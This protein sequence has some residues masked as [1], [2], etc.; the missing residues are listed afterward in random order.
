MGPDLATL[1]KRAPK[2]FLNDKVYKEM[3][4][5]FSH[6]SGWHFSHWKSKDSQLPG[7]AT[8]N[9]GNT[10]L[11]GI[12][13]W[14]FRNFH[15]KV[16]VNVRFYK[17][18]RTWFGTTKKS[19]FRNAFPSF[20]KTCV[21][22]SISPPFFLRKNK[23]L[24]FDGNTSLTSDK[25][26]AFSMI[27]DR[28]LRKWLNLLPNRLR[29]I[30]FLHARCECAN[31][32]FSIVKVAFGTIAKSHQ[33]SAIGVCPFCKFGSDTRHKVSKYNRF[34]KYNR[35]GAFRGREYM[36]YQGIV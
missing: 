29:F 27:L 36:F 31:V 7:N 25:P 12:K 20:L 5:A 15:Q 16:F 22:C 10:M 4:F 34:Y 11:F 33:R 35:L 23:V 28:F 13:F 32:S 3:V 26:N 14:Y 8:R 17:G 6:L 2:V 21:L 30:M 9:S 18:L 24:G 1:P 19:E